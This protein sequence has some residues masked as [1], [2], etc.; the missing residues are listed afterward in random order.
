MTFV[1]S[2]MINVGSEC[3]VYNY[4]CLVLSNETVQK[5]SAIGRRCVVV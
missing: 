3:L 5:S 2:E 1:L 4:S